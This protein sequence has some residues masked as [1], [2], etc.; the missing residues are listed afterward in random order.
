MLQHYPGN[1][2]QMRTMDYNDG[3]DLKG[4]N[5]RKG[6]GK[7]NAGFNTGSTSGPPPIGSAN[8]DNFNNTTAITS[9]SGNVLPPANQV[10]DPVAAQMAM[11]MKQMEEMQKMMQQQ[12]MMF[13]MMMSNS[14]NQSAT[15][16]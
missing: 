6:Y 3:E 8:R 13:Q 7:T 1:D 14:M 10:P 2:A 16:S 5:H 15:M 12:Q 11:Q 4:V 9:G